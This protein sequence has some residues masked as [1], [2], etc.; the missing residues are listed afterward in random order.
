MQIVAFVAELGTVHPQ[1]GAR[2]QA[3]LAAAQ[4]AYDEA[5][6]RVFDGLA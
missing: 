6:R 5:V 3:G 1:A 4:A 2:D